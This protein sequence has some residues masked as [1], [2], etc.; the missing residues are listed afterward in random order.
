[1][2]AEVKNSP[3][4]SSCLNLAVM[5]WDS[6]QAQNILV[7]LRL[8]CS[9]TRTVPAPKPHKSLMRWQSRVVTKFWEIQVTEEKKKSLDTTGTHWR[10][11][12]NRCWELG[13]SPPS[14]PK[15]PPDIKTEGTYTIFLIPGIF[16]TWGLG[17]I[18]KPLIN[19]FFFRAGTRHN[20]FSQSSLGPESPQSSLTFVCKL[21]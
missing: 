5:N 12:D 3:K 6:T 9:Q 1:M 18:W 14:W 20:F 8:I 16:D 11:W 7:M 17:R 13:F 21:N 19:P 10:D 2:F 15:S 4:I